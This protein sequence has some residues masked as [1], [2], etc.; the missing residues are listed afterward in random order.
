M[1]K[2]DNYFEL[3]YIFQACLI[4]YLPVIFCLKSFVECLTYENKKYLCDLLEPAWVAWCINLSFFSLIGSLFLGKYLI[5]DYGIVRISNSDA[6]FW[7]RFFILSKMPEL[8]DTVIIV[9]RSKPLVLL[10]WYHHFATLLICFV[11]YKLECDEFTPYFFMNY[12]VHFFMYAY[13]ALYC[14]FKKRLSSFGT[15]VNVIQTLQMFIAI[16]YSIYLYHF[17]KKFNCEYDPDEDEKKFLFIFG[18]LM[19]SS[20]FGLFIFLFLERRDRLKK[21]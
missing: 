21:D 12:V 6:H 7:Y 10:Q 3:D 16:G 17:H 11:L 2:M 15:F 14:K 1:F 19:Y 8:I 9:L 13:F 18:T 4:A 20:Y 5:Y